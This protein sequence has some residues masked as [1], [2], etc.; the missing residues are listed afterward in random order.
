MIC[1]PWMDR[2]PVPKKTPLQQ[3][4]DDMRY[5]RR[6]LDE[7]EQRATECR[8]RFNEAVDRVASL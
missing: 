4:Q 2:A 1:E 7:A 6:E 5:W 8:K 3:A